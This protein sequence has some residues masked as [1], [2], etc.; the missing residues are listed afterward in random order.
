MGL[1]ACGY[2]APLYIPTPEQ[3]QKLEEREQ[4]IQARKDNAAAEKKAK[5]EQERA[6]PQTATAR[7]GSTGMP[8]AAD[9]TDSNIAP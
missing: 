8:A 9:S 1:S 3:Q 7:S 2:K 4:R 6:N 5:A